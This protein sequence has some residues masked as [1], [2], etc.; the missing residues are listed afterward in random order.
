MERPM[1]KQEVADYL[2]VKVQTIDVYM[3][4]KNIPFHKLAKG[5]M[6]RFYKSEV[7]AWIKEN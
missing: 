3:R 2:Q 4:E 7:D 6:V 1:T 5:R